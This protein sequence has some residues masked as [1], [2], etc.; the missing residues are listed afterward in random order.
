MVLTERW[1]RY[2]QK[3]N[4]KRRKAHKKK[5][6]EMEPAT[7]DIVD[8]YA[9]LLLTTHRLDVLSHP[10]QIWDAIVIGSGMGGLSAAAALAKGGN[11]RVL[12]LEKHTKL[13]G[14]T[15]EFREKGVDFDT[16]LHYVGGEIW[17]NT[18]TARKVFDWITDGMIEWERLDD[19]FDVAVVK[20][21]RYNFRSGLQKQKQDMVARFPEF[22][23]QI[24][25]YWNAVEQ[26]GARF[27]RFLQRQI[28]LAYLP[29]RFVPSIP[30]FGQETVDHALDRLDIKDPTLREVIT[31]LHGDYGAMPSEASWSEHCI[32]ASHYVS[33]AAYPIGG[34]SRIARKA[35]AVIETHGGAAATRAAV[36]SILM[37]NNAAAGVILKGGCVIRAKKVV[38]AIGAYHT[39][40]R[41]LPRELGAQ[42]PV[43]Q[44]ARRQLESGELKASPAH[45]MTFLALKG[46]AQ[47]LGLPK[48]NWWIQ[49]DP[50]FPSVFISF[51]SAKDPSWA[52]RHA[53]ISVCELCVEAPFELFEKWAKDPVKNRDAEYLAAK[54]KLADDMC[55]ILFK[56]FPQLKDKV[57]FRDA[58]TPLSAQ[59]FLGSIRGCAYGLACVPNRYKAEWLQ[60]YTG[61]K[62]LYLGAQDITS[63]GIV[64]GLMGGLIAACSADFNTLWAVSRFFFSSRPMTESS[65][66]WD[67]R[68]E[69]DVGGVAF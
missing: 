27:V 39:Y 17:K 10:N 54:E 56:H 14:C 64:G 3:R 31:Y 38:S 67:P 52:T 2:T 49:D 33:G 9:D 66:Q 45:A 29:S 42:F 58:S 11:H 5:S 46:T 1:H 60:P 48:A 35:L 18:S 61:I 62:N 4:K 34:P 28:L 51:P 6:N 55:D 16:G 41:L 25:A 26:E 19:V 15:H 23:Q 65:T 43:L 13:G 53:G 12:L 7:L 22:S 50:R 69:V 8:N 40:T 24:E 21:E 47:E 20:G 57:I 63:C 36:E 30:D 32:V 37:E 59:H 44:E 68:D